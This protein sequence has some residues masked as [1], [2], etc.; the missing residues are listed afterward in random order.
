[1]SGRHPNGGSDSL[2]PRE[3]DVLELVRRG[4]T[5]AE[6][7]ERLQ[8]SRDTVKHHVS[9]IIAKLGVRNR[10]DAAYWPERPP[11]WMTAFAPVLLAFRRT[12][13]LLRAAAGPTSWL[14]SILMLAALGGLALLAFLLARSGGDSAASR[15]WQELASPAPLFLQEPVRTAGKGWT[16]ETRVSNLNQLE[17]I[18]LLA[19]LPPRITLIDVQT[20][21]PVASGSFGR[22]LDVR[23]REGSPHL[24]VVDVDPEGQ[25]RLLAFDFSSGRAALASQI[26]LPERPGYK[27][28][29]ALATHLSADG[30]YLFVPQRSWVDTPACRDSNRDGKLCS[31]WSI[32]VVDVEAQ[33]L[34]RS[35]PVPAQCY[36]V[37]LLQVDESQPLVSCDAQWL[38]IDG[39]SS[40]RTQSWPSYV[41]PL[42]APGGDTFRALRDDGH[43]VDEDGRPAPRRLVPSADPRVA[44]AWPLGGGRFLLGLN[45]QPPTETRFTGLALANIVDVRL[46]VSLAAPEGTVGVVVLD[47][48][49]A[50]VL[51]QN[52]A[53]YTLHLLD[54][55]AGAWAGTVSV[56]LATDGWVY[57]SR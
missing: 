38:T 6:I 43:V 48:S 11:W 32:G 31:A 7:G 8:I 50:V 1:M 4:F 44:S 16:L 5:N 49:R 39:L 19:E 55:E 15:A 25:D 40:L 12:V 21:R 9:A 18:A 56:A 26:P 34:R 42:S 23:L 10:R 28:S 37:R 52:G 53:R 2:T 24:L 45:P 46:E 20:G 17:L 29:L 47:P 14:A 41:L 22:N 27:S 33:A 30:R 51:A 13:V 3:A 35:I 57:P 36:S 54:L